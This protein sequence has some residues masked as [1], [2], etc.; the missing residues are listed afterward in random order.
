MKPISSPVM[1]FL[2]FL[3]VL[4][5]YP[6]LAQ[7]EGDWDE[8]MQQ[9]AEE[10]MAETGDEQTWEAQ[11]ELLTELHENPLDLNNATRQQL[12]ILPFLSQKAVDAI[13]D[14]RV[15][16][17]VLRTLGELRLIRDLSP[18]ERRWLPL[19]VIIEAGNGRDQN[20]KF[21]SQKRNSLHHDLTTRVDIP[22][23]ER[24]G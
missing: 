15:R 5:P 6:I 1:R 22:L 18:Q 17:G 21:K 3:L 7:S 20:S 14:Y 19:F 13:L 10:Q 2:L 9:M 24:D 8:L 16:N 23:Y 4:L 11:Q 12:M